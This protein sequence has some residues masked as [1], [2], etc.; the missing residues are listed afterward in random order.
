MKTLTPDIIVL[1]DPEGKITRSEE[2]EDNFFVRKLEMVRDSIRF[3]RMFSDE[4]ILDLWKKAEARGW[5]I[6]KADIVV[7][8]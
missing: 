1:I 2:V 5:K 7:R 8:D 3:G 4:E 6:K